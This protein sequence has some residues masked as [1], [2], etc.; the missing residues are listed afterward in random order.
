MSGTLPGTC[1]VV[2]GCLGSIITDDVIKFGLVGDD[3][4]LV[5]GKEQFDLIQGPIVSNFGINIGTD[6]VAAGIAVSSRVSP[7]LQQIV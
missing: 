4:V 1:I 3:A 6:A 7:L 2:N 5:P